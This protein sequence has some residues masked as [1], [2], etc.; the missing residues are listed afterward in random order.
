MD[1]WHID[2]VVPMSFFNLLDDLDMA[3]CNHWINLRPAW[4]AM[5]NAKGKRINPDTAEIIIALIWSHLL[6]DQSKERL[7]RESGR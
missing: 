2:H 5:N 4:A 7:N 3:V 6:S 1:K